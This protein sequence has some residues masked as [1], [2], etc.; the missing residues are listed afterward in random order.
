MRLAFAEGA[1][2]LHT[3]YIQYITHTLHSEYDTTESTAYLVPKSTSP[4][5]SVCG[6]DRKAHLH[7]PQEAAENASPLPLVT[8]FP[9]L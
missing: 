9:L 8:H 5:E 3:I 4:M 1:V 2:A 7:S 6:R